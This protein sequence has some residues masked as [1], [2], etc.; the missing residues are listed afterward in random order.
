MA[1]ATMEDG[2]RVKMDCSIAAVK[3]AVSAAAKALPAGKFWL[4]IK[5]SSTYIKIQETLWSAQWN[6][7]GLDDDNVKATIQ[8][9]Q[10]W[11]KDHVR[12][13][14]KRRAN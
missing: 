8:G 4:V 5:G 6:C 1:K 10:T 9:L 14:R 13:A 7:D 2:D 11:V 3:K 12:L